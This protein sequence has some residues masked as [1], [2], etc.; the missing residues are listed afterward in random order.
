MTPFVILMS[1]LFKHKVG[2]FFA[3]SFDENLFEGHLRIMYK[4]QGLEITLLNTGV[5]SKKRQN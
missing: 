1:Y 4:V 3:R 5:K 2:R